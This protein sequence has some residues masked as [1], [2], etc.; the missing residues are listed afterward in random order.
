MHFCDRLDGFH[1]K[2]FLKESASN[3]N[4]PGSRIPRSCRSAACMHLLAFSLHFVSTDARASVTCISPS[5]QGLYLL[6]AELGQP[7]MEQA[8]E[9]HSGHS[10]TYSFSCFVHSQHLG[11]QS[12]KFSIAT[13]SQ[14]SAQRAIPKFRRFAGDPD[15][16]HEYRWQWLGRPSREQRQ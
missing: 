11:T 2:T 4:Q 16:L 7:N 1:V 9:L 8:A 5:P 14:D 13:A 3:L 10:L 12:P 6:N 15:I